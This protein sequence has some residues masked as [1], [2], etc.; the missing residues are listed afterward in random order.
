MAFTQTLP[1]Y[2]VCNIA[3]CQHFI[4]TEEGYRLAI[5]MQVTRVL[6]EEAPCHFPLDIMPLKDKFTLK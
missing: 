1:S 4:E 3:N 2:P 5:S 6:I